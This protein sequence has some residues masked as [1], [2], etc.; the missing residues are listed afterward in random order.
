[1]FLVKIKKFKCF[2]F[3]S[4]DFSVIFGWDLGCHHLEDCSSFFFKNIVVP[5]LLVLGNKAMQSKLYTEAIELYTFAIALCE[6]N[7][8]Y[9][10]NR[11]VSYLCRL[12]VIHSMS[13]AFIPLNE[14]LVLS[15]SHMYCW[16]FFKSLALT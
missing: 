3:V 10:C 11:S 12:K 1:M 5:H 14:I 4:E 15:I 7:A 8:V 6:G 13:S 16:V 2:F 9:Y